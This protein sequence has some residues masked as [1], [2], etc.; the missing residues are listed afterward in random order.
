M[1]DQQETE[2]REATCHYFKRPGQDPAAPYSAAVRCGN[3][4][5]TCGQLGTDPR[6]RLPDTFAEQVD[7]AFDNLETALKIGGADLSTLIK[8]SAFVLDINQLEAFNEVYK[9]RV[10]PEAPPVRTTVQIAAFQEN[11]LV[12]LDA[13]AYAKDGHSA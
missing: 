3:L 6:G 8:V 9:R 7:L 1:T 13:V 10:N 2:T 11:I 5:W 4:V 12:E